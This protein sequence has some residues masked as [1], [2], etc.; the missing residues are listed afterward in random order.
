MANRK[1]VDWGVCVRVLCEFKKEK[2]EIKTYQIICWPANKEI[3]ANRE[4][5][6]VHCLRTK[7]NIN[8]NN[9]NR[10][11]LSNYFFL[12]F[13]FVTG[14]D[15]FYFYAVLAFGVCVWEKVQVFFYVTNCR[16]V[17]CSRSIGVP[18]TR[19]SLLVKNDNNK[20]EKIKYKIMC[21]VFIEMHALCCIRIVHNDIKMSR[22]VK[23]F[24]QRQTA[25][26]SQP[27]AIISHAFKPTNSMIRFQ[28]T[29]HTHSPPPCQLPSVLLHMHMHR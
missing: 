12:S 14:I 5:E 13:G 2:E 11:E 8:S 26:P 4:K 20:K 23:T 27:T 7:R 10:H 18:R 15:T 24:E 29:T 9:S 1:S 22:N 3:V 19:L 6:N 16:A 21:I 28:T 17:F 25:H